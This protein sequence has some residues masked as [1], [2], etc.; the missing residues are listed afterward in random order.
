VGPD[1]GRR[2]RPAGI[3]VAQLRG[4]AR[5]GRCSRHSHSRP[6]PGL[7]FSEGPGGC[8]ALISL[9]SAVK[10]R[11]FLDASSDGDDV[12]FL[13]AGGRPEGA[14]HGTRGC[15]GGRGTARAGEPH[16]RTRP[17]LSDLARRGIRA[18]SESLE[19]CFA[20]RAPARRPFPLRLSLQPHALRLR[21]GAFADRQADAHLGLLGV[22]AHP[23]PDLGKGDGDGVRAPLQ[24][25]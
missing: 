12:F 9:G 2:P 25:A 23:D 24:A 17:I 8:L 5:I 11:L 20:L 14:G 16:R 15:A 7:R 13:N 4:A 19:G 22:L 18:P 10:D 3:G 1:G 6:A 21:G